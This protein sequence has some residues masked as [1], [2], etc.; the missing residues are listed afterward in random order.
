[1]NLSEVVKMVEKT[2]ND[3]FKVIDWGANHGNAGLISKHEVATHFDILIAE[4]SSHHDACSEPARGDSSYGVQ[5]SF[6]NRVLSCGHDRD[7]YLSWVARNYDEPVIGQSCF[8]R[9][10]NCEKNVVEVE[11]LCIN[12]QGDGLDGF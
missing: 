10:C 3:I 9:L 12:F 5:K 7:T 11:L 8:C 6:W 4:I 2:R 1:M